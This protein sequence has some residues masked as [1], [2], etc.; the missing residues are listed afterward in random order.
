MD[1]ADNN[2]RAA[3]SWQAQLTQQFYTWELRGRGWHVWDVP[4]DPE[5]AFVPFF[6]YRPLF[7]GLECDDGRKHTLISGMIDWLHRRVMGSFR[8]QTPVEDDPDAKPAQPRLCYQSGELAELQLSLPSTLQIAPE[9]AEQLLI[10]IGTC[11][12][13]PAFELLGLPDRL[14]VQFACDPGAA[15][16]TRQQIEAFLPE[17]TVVQQAQT[18]ETAWRDAGG[19]DSI[20]AELGLARE[21]MLPL[22]AT[23]RSFAVDPLTA[24]L[25]VLSDVGSNEV[26]LLQVIFQPVRHAWAESVLRSVVQGDGVPLF[27]GA[28]DY[29]K[30]AKEKVSCPLYGAVIRVAARSWEDDRASELGRRMVGALTCLNDAGGNELIPLDN[31]GYDAEQHEDDLMLRRSRRSGILLNSAELL[32]LVHPP[33]A[34]IQLAKLRGGVRKTKSAPANASQPCCTLGENEHAGQARP[35]SLTREQR[36]RHVHIVGASGTGKSTLLLNLILQD[37]RAGDGVAVL[38]PHGDLIDD[39]LARLPDNRVDDVVL[40]DPSDEDYPVGLNVLSAHSAMEKNLLSSDLVAVF[41]RMSTSWGDQMNAVLANAILAFLESSRGGTLLDLRRFLVETGYRKQFLATVQDAEVVY[42]WT[43]EFPLLVGRS[44]SSV[45]TRLNTFLRPKPIRYMVAQQQSRLDFGKIMDDGKILLARLSHGAIGQENAYLLGTLLVSKFHQLALGRQRIRESERRYFWLYVDEFQNFATPSMAALLSGARKYRLGLVL[46]HQEMRQ[47]ESVA[48]DV[49]AAVLTNA[50]ARVCFRLGDED[51]R[52]LANG[53]SAFDARDLQSLGRGEAVCRLERADADFS[54]RTRVVARHDEARAAECRDRVLDNT[55]TRFAVRREAIEALLARD[56]PPTDTSEDVESKRPRVPS[57]RV[58]TATDARVPRSSTHDL[59]GPR[60]PPAATVPQPAEP[61]PQG[62]G[63]PQ[64][65]YLQRL[66]KQFAEGLGYRASIEENVLQGRGVDVGLTKGDT[67]IACEI[68][69]T[70]E[71]AHELENVRKCLAAGYNQ[72]VVVT[73]EAGRMASLRRFIEAGLSE[74]EKRVVHFF[75]PEEFF[76]FVR[77]LEVRQ[78]DRERMV[79][80]YKVKTKFKPVEADEGDDR[81]QAI[82]QV[83]AKALRRL[84]D[85][86]GK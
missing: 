43:R 53:F 21:F 3:S 16:H 9:A 51:A 11:T 7:D 54:L 12:H 80:G 78:L 2:E 71:H 14:V 20:V 19:G 52:K 36:A 72:V 15:I 50:F 26:A 49:A 66:I 41:R 86:S 24:I 23:R 77:D 44:H 30:K 39:V 84:N 70:T 47:L 59:P 55:R 37:V 35:V 68:C 22:Q 40:L 65:R 75:V 42:Y 10:S 27:E 60:P 25:G 28:R 45:L 76:A 6:G 8:R 31:E 29:L 56:A 13:T 58:P 4:V 74:D 85:R 73:P 82:S 61:A 32:S 67:T 69:I 63:G 17:V 79:R 18:L 46:A 33:S 81:R 38:D 62:R 83:V 5:P 64:H 48:P 34:S 57:A 1:I